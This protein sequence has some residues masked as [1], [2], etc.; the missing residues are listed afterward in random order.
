M[1]ELSIDRTRRDGKNPYCKECRSREL[2]EYQAKRKRATEE[3]V[4][5]D[6]DDDGEPTEPAGSDPVVPWLLNLRVGSYF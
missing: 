5:G 6:E 4:V 1:K 3:D 2:K